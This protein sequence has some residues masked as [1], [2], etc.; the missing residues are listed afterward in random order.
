MTAAEAKQLA[1]EAKDKEAAAEVEDILKMIQREAT[2]GSFQMELD[3]LTMGAK[4]KL[5]ALD[6]K[7]DYDGDDKFFVIRWY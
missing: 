7:V 2:N 3:D 6:Y 5:I 4:E 1:T